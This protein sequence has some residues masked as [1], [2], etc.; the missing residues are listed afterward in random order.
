MLI[1]YHQ[2]AA[3]TTRTWQDLS[4][5]SLI[6]LL[7]TLIIWLP[8]FLG[9]NFYGLDF[10]NGFATIYRN[11]DGLEYVVI[12]KS[13]YNPNLISGIPYSI[14][15]IYYASHFLLYPLLILFF[16]QF[17]GFLKSMLLVSVLSTLGAAIAFYLLV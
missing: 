8:H 16:A 9:I 4:L 15:P 3:M 12:A 11:Y 5:I 2:K 6:T 13:F 7:L 17:L 14:S 10:S 1:C